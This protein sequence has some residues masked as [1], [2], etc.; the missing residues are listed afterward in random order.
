MTGAPKSWTGQKGTE[1]LIS[2]IKTDLRY[3]T[4]TLLTKPQMRV[5][6]DEKQF[7]IPN[8]LKTEEYRGRLGNA[9]S[10]DCSGYVPKDTLELGLAK[11][12]ISASFIKV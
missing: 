12:M 7:N 5:I 9:L 6:A 10:G 8:S 1:A 2:W 4:L 3:R 11:A